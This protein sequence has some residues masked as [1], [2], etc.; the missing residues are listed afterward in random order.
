MIAVIHLLFG[1]FGA[2]IRLEEFDAYKQ[3]LEEIRKQATSKGRGVVFFHELGDMLPYVPY[4][5]FESKKELRAFHEKRD[6]LSKVFKALFSGKFHEAPE[7]YRNLVK[8]LSHNISLYKYLCDNHISVVQE[9]LSSERYRLIYKAFFNKFLA[10]ESLAR[11]FSY[12]R[13]IRSNPHSQLY[14][15]L[16]SEVMRPLVKQIIQRDVKLAKQLEN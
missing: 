3:K 14:T 2:P 1:V 8:W 6:E 10:S 9:E 7:R 15:K 11:I 16:F 13:F 5:P 4:K 12:N